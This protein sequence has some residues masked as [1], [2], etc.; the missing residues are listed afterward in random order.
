[1]KFRVTFKTPDVVEDCIREAIGD[2]KWEKKLTDEFT[3]DDNDS[4]RETLDLVSNKWFRYG[5]YVTIEVD[6]E[7]DTAIVIKNN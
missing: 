7:A 6:S 4:V 2:E 1:M 5:E 3:Q